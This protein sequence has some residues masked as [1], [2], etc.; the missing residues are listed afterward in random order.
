MAWQTRDLVV[1]SGVSVAASAYF[2][3]N[4]FLVEQDR[5]YS[6][7]LAFTYASGTTGSGTAK[8]QTSN[9]GVSWDD[10][11]SLATR[12]SAAYTNATTALTFEVPDKCHKF[13]RLALVSVGGTGGTATVYFHGEAS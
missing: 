12:S 1:A 2:P 5:R 11:I 13:T 10:R 6:L 9:D 7:Q 8:V 4:G 3:V